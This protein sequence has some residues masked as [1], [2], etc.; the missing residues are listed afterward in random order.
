MLFLQIVISDVIQSSTDILITVA[1]QS[2]CTPYIHHA[3]NRYTY[4][5]SLPCDVWIDFAEEYR[6]VVR[7]K[8]VVDVQFTLLV[9]V[10][11][12]RVV[13]LIAERNG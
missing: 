8:F 10:L 3:C 7:R 4:V 1:S 9:A 6:F 5:W 13:S 11:L 12:Q 2:H